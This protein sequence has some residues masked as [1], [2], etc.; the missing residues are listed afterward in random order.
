MKIKLIFLLL[1]MFLLSCGAKQPALKNGVQRDE[2]PEWVN[3]P[4]MN[5]PAKKYLTAVGI[6]DTRT[7]AEDNARGNLAKIFQSDIKVDH[8]MMQNIMETD[9]ELKES[10]QMLTNTNVKS[11]QTLKNI[12]IGDAWFSPG[13]G[14]YYVI[15]YLDRFETARIYTEEMDKN[16]ALAQNAYKNAVSEEKLLRRYAFLNKA[17]NALVI[18]KMLA[19]QLLII[20]PNMPYN[21]PAELENN[22]NAELENTRSR[23]TCNIRA[24]GDL[25]EDVLASL[26]EMVAK[27]MF[28]VIDDPGNAKL[29]FTVKTSLKPVTLNA[30]GVYFIYDVSIG[31]KDNINHQTLETFN[32]TGREGQVDES[33]ARKRVAMAVHKKI[34]KDYYKKLSQYIEG[35]VK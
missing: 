23:I 21:E 1:P 2:R 9:T 24:E 6:G 11:N 25:R 34:T 35:N 4:E 16:E 5:Y 19:S 12:K 15:A 26:K 10:M 13:E 8:T 28:P 3:N 18:N 22:I 27:F 30:P 29:Q 14:R 31:L 17:K 20:N 32:A 33:G 7:A